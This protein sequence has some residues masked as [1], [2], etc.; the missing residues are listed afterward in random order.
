MRMTSL[1][2]WPRT[3]TDFDTC[4]ALGVSDDDLSGL[5]VLAPSP[6]GQTS[7]FAFDFRNGTFP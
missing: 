1:E 2:G 4:F 6:P 3:E 5:F 7:I